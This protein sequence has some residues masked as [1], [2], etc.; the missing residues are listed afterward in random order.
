MV[1]LRGWGHDA[2]A[3]F[4][5][6]EVLVAIIVFWALLSNLHSSDDTHTARHRLRARQKDETPR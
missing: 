1:L 6:L 4:Q 5:A 3:L 2:G